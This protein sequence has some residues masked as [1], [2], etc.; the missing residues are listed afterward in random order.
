MKKEKRICKKGHTYF[1]S[2]T[3]PVCPKCESIKKSKDEFLSLV[4]AP[5]RRALI[6]AGI[7]SIE[8][9]AKNSEKEILALHGMG[10]ST[11]PILKRKL[12]ECNLKF[13][14]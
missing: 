3:C 2:S 7:T 11:I 14:S 10:P 8:L 13:K 6:Q 4:A 1:K 12:K 5:A 9:L